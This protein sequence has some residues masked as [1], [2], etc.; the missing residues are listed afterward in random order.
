ME[1]KEIDIN[2]IKQIENVR[3]KIKDNELASLMSSIQQHGLQQPIGLFK[4]K[5]NSEYVIVFGNRRLEA[6]KK[7]GFKTI[8][9]KIIESLNNDELI[10]LNLVENIQRKDINMVELGRMCSLL[11]QMQLT[12]EEIAVRLSIPKARVM[13]ALL[14]YKIIPKKYAELVRYQQRGKNSRNGLIPAV[15]AVTIASSAN[16]H[17]L[18]TSQVEYLMERAR[19]NNLKMEEVRKLAK[20]LNNGIEFD[21]AVKMVNECQYYSARVFVL[22]NEAEELK[23]K[24]HTSMNNILRGIVYGT[25]KESLSKVLEMKEND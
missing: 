1:V 9:A 3:V 12:E 10:T 24:Y 4:P 19:N 20:L 22:K 15:V 16:E 11:K 8:T 18:T 2:K 5:D 25:Y 6:C 17:R 14:G 23:K 7:L 21:K 13:S